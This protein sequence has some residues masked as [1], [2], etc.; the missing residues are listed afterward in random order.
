MGGRGDQVLY[1][2]EAG[3]RYPSKGHLKN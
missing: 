1:E 2:N 3:T